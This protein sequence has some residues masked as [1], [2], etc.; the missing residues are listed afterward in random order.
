MKKINYSV[1]FL[2]FTSILY[3][4]VENE[5]NPP[6]YIKT[7]NFKGNTP[8]SQLPIFKIR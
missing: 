4:Q 8:E 1:I 2:L 5:I 6:D 3:S 7:I